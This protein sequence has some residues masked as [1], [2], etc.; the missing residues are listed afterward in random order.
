MLR[1]NIKSAIARM[2]PSR[3]AGTARPAPTGMSLA[4][5][6]LEAVAATPSP[7]SPPAT[8]PGQLPVVCSLLAEGVHFQGNMVVKGGIKIEGV[9]NGNVEVTDGGVL[10]L[11]G[12]VTGN[13]V[14]STAFINGA[15]H[16]DVFASRILLGPNGHVRGKVS[17]VDMHWQQGACVDGEVRRTDDPLQEVSATSGRVV[18]TT[19]DQGT[20]SQPRARAPRRN[21]AA[22][23]ATAR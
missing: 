15:V 2:F 10:I 19:V 12:H 22:K 14:A 21:A 23:A 13:V 3:G 18:N 4:P 1:L 11:T 6:N 16:G 20:P 7:Q 5:T 8:T 17:Y 9:V